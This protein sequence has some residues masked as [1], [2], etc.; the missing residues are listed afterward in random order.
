MNDA[1]VPMRPPQRFAAALRRH[2]VEYLFGQSNPPALTLACHDLG[3]TQIGYRQ[4]N[5][6]AYMADGYA[7]ATGRVPVVTAQNGPA[8]TLLVPGLAECLSASVPRRASPGCRTGDARP[9]RV[10]RTGP[11]GV[12]QRSLQVDTPGDERGSNRGLR[13]HGVHCCRERPSRSCR[14]SGLDGIARRK[15]GAAR[16]RALGAPRL[17]S[18]RSDGG[19]PRTHRHGSRAFGQGACAPCLC[20]R[21]GARFGAPADCHSLRI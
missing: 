5:A 14:P 2:G 12:L 21:R 6:G 18:A 17:L 13:R 4:E 19:R 7:R 15:R 9:Q 10:P 16:G 20:R 11:V 1:P 8:A 3:I